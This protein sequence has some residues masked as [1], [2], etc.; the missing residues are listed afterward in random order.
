MPCV[1]RVLVVGA[2]IAGLALAQKLGSL[3]IEVEILE[4]KSRV[5]AHGAG[6]LLTGNAVRVLHDLGLDRI[7]SER[8]R[9]VDVIR[10][11]DEREREL[12]RVDC[13]AQHGWP[14]FVSIQ[15]DALQRILL[16]AVMPLAPRWGTTIVSL[17][18]LPD[19]MEAV[20]SD[21]TR[22]RYGLV[23]GADGVHSQ[24]RNLLFGDRQIEPIPGYRGWRFLAPCP[25]GLKAPQYMLGNART[26]LLHPL[27]GGEVY[28]GAGPVVEANLE[29][30]GDLERMRGAFAA[31]GG[32]AAEVLASQKS[33]SGLIPTR[34]W[35]LEQRP[36][37]AGGCVLIGDAAHA[38]APTLA[39]GGAMALEDAL[40][41]G[42]LL[43]HQLERT[44]A[45]L[46]FEARRAPRVIHAQTASLQRMV[47]NRPLDPRAVALRDAILPKVGAAQLLDDWAPLMEGSP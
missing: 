41:L 36:W 10:F 26:L 13:S 11:T 20:L 7:L 18:A 25:S 29:G 9:P 3:G 22:G 24:V 27:P 1:E 44:D 35:H 43:G 4:R 31:F 34:Y 17:Q 39:Q 6:I 15:R 45:L 30:N 47:A 21:G 33:S 28:C 16:D 5:E 40:V 19:C 37:H 38:C 2:G 23:V 12:F 46:A 32:F 14:Q 8:S 42:E